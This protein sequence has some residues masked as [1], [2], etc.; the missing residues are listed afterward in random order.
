M[1]GPWRQ[2]RV[3]S[4]KVYDKATKINGQES[5]GPKNDSMGTIKEHDHMSL[6]IYVLP[7]E[8]APLIL[9]HFKSQK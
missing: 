4:F 2:F 3:L 5:I 7:S 6:P 9:I 1:I 8:P